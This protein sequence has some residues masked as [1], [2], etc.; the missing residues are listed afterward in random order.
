[1]KYAGVFKKNHL[2]TYSRVDWQRCYEEGLAHGFFK[3][4]KNYNALKNTLN[5]S[6]GPSND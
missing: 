2:T 6:N 4:Y 5:Q 1:M 3:T